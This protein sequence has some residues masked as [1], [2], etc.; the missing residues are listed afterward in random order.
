MIGD[1]FRGIDDTNNGGVVAPGF[2]NFETLTKQIF[3]CANVQR[4]LIFMLLLLLLVRFAVAV[5][6]EL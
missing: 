5:F 6:V 4:C 1:D 3:F 2:D